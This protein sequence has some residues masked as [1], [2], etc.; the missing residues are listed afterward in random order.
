[1]KFVARLKNA[2]MAPRKVRLLREALIGL[3]VPDALAQLQFQSGKAA[4]VVFEVLRSA[5]ANAQ[6][7]FD[8]AP[9][10]LRVVAVDVNE[11][12]VLKRWQPASKGMAHPYQK[13]ASHIAVAVGEI[14]GSTDPP[15]AGRKSDIETVSV[16]DLTATHEPAAQDV[17]TEIAPA[18]AEVTAPAPD[19][20]MQAFQKK[21]IQQQGGDVHK[22][23]RRKS[24]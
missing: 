21:K 15:R 19:K 5:V 24:G 22:T 10:T 11:G 2:R 4:E 23:H 20:A 17:P 9:D 6:H 14:D 8:L 13:R 3:P 1:M 12:M 7:N 16:A 18:P